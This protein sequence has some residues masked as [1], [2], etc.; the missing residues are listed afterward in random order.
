MQWMYERVNLIL[1]ELGSKWQITQ[2]NARL[3]DC[4]TKARKVTEL[5][6]GVQY[7]EQLAKR[8]G[9]AVKPSGLSVGERLRHL[10]RVLQSKDD[11]NGFGHQVD[12]EQVAGI[13]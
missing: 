11:Q 13:G 8:Q 12:I 6:Y 9:Y 4:D 3:F 7:A 10:E 1:Q 5:T 2:P